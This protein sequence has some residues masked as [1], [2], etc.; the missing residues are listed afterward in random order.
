MDVAVVDVDTV[1]AEVAA[2]VGLAEGESGIRDIL[3]AVLSAEPAAVREVAR[4]AE[5]PVPIVA[6]ACN[7]LRLARRDRLA[8]AGAADSRRPGS[9]GRGDGRAATAGCL[10]GLRRP[11]RGHPARAGRTRRGTAAQ[12]GRRAR[13]QGRA[14][15]DPLHGGDQDQPRAPACGRACAGWP[16]DP[17]ARGRR[18][19]QPGDRP[20]RG[21][22]RASRHDPAAGRG[23]RRPGRARLDRRPGR[24]YWRPARTGPSRSPAAAA[25]RSPGA[26]TW[27]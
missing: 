1:V 6:A 5:L 24:R 8:A 18:P 16:A 3:A 27:C 9:G 11:R 20:V 23:R 14:R 26:S 13:R 25:G 21:P 12:R 15:S 2:A 7:E 17:G 4:L 19:D 22:P 10:P